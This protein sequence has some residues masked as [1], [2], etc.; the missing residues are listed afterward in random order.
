MKL[1]RPKVIRLN[2]SVIKSNRGLIIRFTISKIKDI[3]SN[4][5]ILPI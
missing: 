5:L 2:G 4:E 1:N 3:T